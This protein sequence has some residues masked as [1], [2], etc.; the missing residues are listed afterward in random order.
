MQD[1]VKEASEQ[2]WTSPLPG[3]LGKMIASSMVPFPDTYWGNRLKNLEEELPHWRRPIERLRTNDSLRTL[4]LALDRINDQIIAPDP[5]NLF[6]AYSE[7]AMKNVNVVFLGQDPY[8]SSDRSCQTLELFNSM[9][10]EEVSKIIGSGYADNAL[11]KSIPWLSESTK[12]RP[13]VQLK[14][15]PYAIGKSFAYPKECIEPPGSYVN[16]QKCLIASVGK[17]IQMDPELKNWSSQGVLMLN[18]CPHLYNKSSKNPNVWTAWTSEILGSITKTRPFCVFV[19]LG[20]SAKSFK[21]DIVEANSAACIIETGHPSLRNSNVG[22][23]LNCDVFRRINDF[24]TSLE[25]PAIQW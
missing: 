21:A 11:T 4:A 23:F 25:L 8:P 24:R 7:L 9:S 14:A 16:L 6:R 2:Q 13:H 3:I 12:T 19:L 10:H 20:N 17:K 5:D 22:D 18:A 15:I 1:L